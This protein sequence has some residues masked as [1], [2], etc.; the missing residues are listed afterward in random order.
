MFGSTQ[1]SPIGFKA[2]V[3]EAVGIFARKQDLQAASMTC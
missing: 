2:E 3:R 1:T